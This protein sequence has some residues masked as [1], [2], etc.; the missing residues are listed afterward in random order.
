MV[1][2]TRTT[3]DE[4]GDLAVMRFEGDIMST[5]ADA[6]LGRYRRLQDGISKIALDFTRVP[7]LNSSGIGLVIQLLIAAGKMQQTV[8]CFGL[9]AHFAKVFTLLGL[10]KYTTLYPDEASALAALA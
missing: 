8:V 9:S 5:S 4:T 2:P 1:A 10:A 3:V 6:V 7:Y